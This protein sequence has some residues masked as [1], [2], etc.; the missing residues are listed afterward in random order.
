MTKIF[1]E[2]INEATLKVTSDDFGV[3]QELCDFF[4]F[5]VPGAKFMPTYKAKNQQAWATLTS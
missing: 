3:E 5:D 4:T 2:K 1:I